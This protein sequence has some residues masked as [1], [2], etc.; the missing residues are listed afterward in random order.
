MIRLFFSP[1]EGGGGPPAAPPADPA[2]A[3]PA[4][5]P[6]PEPEP[7]P[8][9]GWLTQVPKELREHPSLIK[10]GKMGDLLQDYIELS[11]KAE[12][13]LYLPG[14]DAKP[15]EIQAFLKK[16]GIPESAEGYEL[17]EKLVKDQPGGKEFLEA[18][19][20]MAHTAG[21]TK[22]QAAKSLEFVAG[23]ARSGGEAQKAAEKQ[24]RETFDARLL[25]AVGGNADKAQETRN[26]LISFMAKR[27]GDQEL[28]KDMAAK[29]ILYDVRYVRLF[30]QLEER[31]GD[32]PF[33][34]GKRK[35]P[36]EAKSKG[37]QGHYSAEFDAAYG[38]KGS[39]G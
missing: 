17:D 18:F 21:M 8:A 32:A 36:P 34:D 13:A 7:K 28:V 33:V 19:R 26:R 29:G 15:E 37:K 20:T 39:S 11:G 31:V 23:I 25:E 27:V 24:A 38:G 2:P 6:A 3:A 30:A 14:K 12:R 4:A 5:E 10:H 16:M 1:D 9:T 35:G 22:K